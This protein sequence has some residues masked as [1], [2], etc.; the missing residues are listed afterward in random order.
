LTETKEKMKMK[1]LKDIPISVLDL[2]TIPEG[3]TAADTFQNSLRV[4]QQ[5]EKFGFNR[6]WLSEHHNMIS[7]ASSATSVLI[8]FIAGGTSKMRVGSGGIMLPNHSPLAVAEQ[9]GTLESL[10]P[11]RI[12]LGLGRAPGTDQLTA[13]ALR[14]DFFNNAQEFPQNVLKLQAYFSEENKN[15]KVRAIPGEGLHI[16]IWILGSSTDSAQLAAALGLPYAFASHF[17]PAQFFAAIKLYRENFRPSKYLSEPYVMPCV[18]VIA[19]DTDEEAQKLAT[20]LFQ[21]FMGIITG[22]R[23]KLQ[24]PVDDMSRIWSDYEKQMA[25]Q[26]LSLSFIGSKE[27]IKTGLEDFLEKTRCDEIMAISNLYDT[28]AKIHSY[29]IL[30]EV[31]GKR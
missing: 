2:A 13:M 3:Q 12:D 26:M 19:A 27:T 29:E 14:G 28:N 7:V 16:P 4:A 22:Q 5:V 8:G 21:M 9:F 23:T 24:P 15:S 1:Q 11:G 6:Y 18:N 31:M 20:S 30:A 17:A 10:Y 25:Q